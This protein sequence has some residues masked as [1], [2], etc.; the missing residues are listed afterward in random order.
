MSMNYF[1]YRLSMGLLITLCSS[2]LILVFSCGDAAYRRT[3]HGLQYKIIVSR[4]AK[5][6]SLGDRMILHLSYE[7]SEGKEIYN[8]SV[9]GDDFVLELTPPTF[10]GGIEEGFSMMGEGD[11][12]HF[13]LPADSV[14]GKTFNLPLPEGIKPGDQLLFKVKMKSVIPAQEHQKK[15][16][17]VADSV[18]LADAIAMNTYIKRNNITAHPVREGVYFIVFEEGRG[19]KPRAGD[20]VEV[21]YTATFLD[22]SVFDASSGN[23]ANLRYVLGDGL[24]LKAWDEA[25]ASLRPGGVCRLVLSSAE[26]FGT[27]GYGPVPPNTPV[28]YNINLIR[29]IGNTG[30]EISNRK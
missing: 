26:A 9:L 10:I 25:I 23:G 3:D 20:S 12:A 16:K 14:F 18:A 6:P 17:A 1:V 22:G 2:F 7:N 28:V 13:L 11:S 19:D 5:R 29:V 21:S 15:M 30:R 8:S 27:R 4:N 24:R